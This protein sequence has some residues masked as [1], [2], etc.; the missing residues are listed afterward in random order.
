MWHVR[1]SRIIWMALNPVTEWF[2]DLISFLR[3]WQ[4]DNPLLF[5]SKSQ[6]TLIFF[7]NFHFLFQFHFLSSSS[8]HEKKVF[9]FLWHL[10]ESQYFNSRYSFCDISLWKSNILFLTSLENVL[11]FDFF[12]FSTW[13]SNWGAKF[14]PY[15]CS[16]CLPLEPTFY[17]E[18]TN[19]FKLLFGHMALCVQCQIWT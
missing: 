16:L 19:R 1:V 17:V 6:R 15:T 10:N 12:S 11:T 14:W 8:S 18:S 9:Y 5:P 13:T 4:N 2:L 7:A 3:L